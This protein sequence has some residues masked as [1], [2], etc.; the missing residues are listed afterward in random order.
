MAVSCS[1]NA[2]DKDCTFFPD[3][4]NILLLSEN[5]TDRLVVVTV[6]KSSMHSEKSDGP[7][8]GLFV[9]LLLCYVLHIAND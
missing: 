3:Q 6:V 5:K 4:K 9:T 2:I 8:I 1:F 7:K